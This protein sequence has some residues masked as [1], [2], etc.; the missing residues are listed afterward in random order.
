MQL[1]YV[2]G[3]HGV[4][5]HG[6]SQVSTV[7]V[8]GSGTRCVDTWAGAVSVVEYT[9][10]SHMDRHRCSECCRGTRC[11]DTWA[12][13]VSVVGYTVFRHMDRHRCSECCRGTRC[14]ATWTDT[15]AVSVAGVHGP[16]LSPPFF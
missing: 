4:Q 5:T 10:C 16:V 13:A 2:V 15:G 3:V 1:G 12:G 8:A 6:Q 11:V 14:V 9:V 7:S